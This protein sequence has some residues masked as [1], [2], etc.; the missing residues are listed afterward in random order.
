[1]AAVLGPQIHV[2]FCTDRRIMIV[3]VDGV[4]TVAAP[5]NRAEV[6][7]SLGEFPDL[8]ST[9]IPTER[10]PVGSVV[11]HRE[12]YYSDCSF[13]PPFALVVYRDSHGNDVHIKVALQKPVLRI[14]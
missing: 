14:P 9:T 5:Y 3:E 8:A 2:R 4:K 10:I 13:D 1:M 7:K 12:R 6:V 11:F